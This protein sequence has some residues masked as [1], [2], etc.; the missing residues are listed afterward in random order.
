[1]RLAL[2]YIWNALPAF[3]I[4]CG[5]AFTGGHLGWR[6]LIS[7]VMCIA[8]LEWRADTAYRLGWDAGLDA[9]VDLDP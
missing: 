3:V 6:W 5:L 2:R 4:G 1:M 8:A 7:L 9:M